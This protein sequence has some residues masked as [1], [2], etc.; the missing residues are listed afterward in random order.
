[1]VLLVG[2]R[3]PQAVE[4][5]ALIAGRQAK[6]D[7]AG[8]NTRKPADDRTG[9]QV[10]VGRIRNK[11]ACGRTSGTAGRWVLQTTGQR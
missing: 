4:S 1:M 9:K 8:C 11:G 7:T 5:V 6:F 10:A 2:S 3:R